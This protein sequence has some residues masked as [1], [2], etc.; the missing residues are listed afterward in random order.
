MPRKTEWI[1]RIPQ[2][3]EV[4]RQSPAPLIGRR[5]LEQLLSVSARNALRILN[6]LGA[7][8]AGRNLFIAREE[9][10]GRLEAVH[11]G[12][13][14]RY[15]R[16][17]LTRLDAT[18]ASLQRDLRARLVPVAADPAA[19]NL[20]FPSLP[21]SVRLLPGRLEID[22]RTPEELLTRLFELSQ[23]MAND[24]ESFRSTISSPGP[25][26]HPVSALPV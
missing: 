1:H 4:L 9:L 15:E 21:S 26:V 5:D 20:L 23:A 13:E 19:R 16:R 22:F 6:R 2:A 3:L 18:L 24:Y 12:G 7:A 11:D 25:P 14:A 10:I 17:R 8:E